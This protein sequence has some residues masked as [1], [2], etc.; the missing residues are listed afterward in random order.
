MGSVALEQPR[1]ARHRPQK[2]RLRRR[3]PHCRAPGSL[4]VRAFQLPQ[5]R[6]SPLR[7]GSERSRRWHHRGDEGKAATTGA[8]GLLLP[9]CLTW[10]GRANVAEHVG[11]AASPWLERHRAWMVSSHGI[12]SH[13]MLQSMLPLAPESLVEATQ[14]LWT[15]GKALRLLR[16]LAKV[17][18]EEGIE[19]RRACVTG[20][21]QSPRWLCLC[22]VPPPSARA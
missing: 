3:R 1:R 15:A 12:L 21:P 13:G 20:S 22:A 19:C 6:G 14:A 8:S 11:H 10:G 2:E 16:F 9:V 4:A 5:P 18:E 17:G 7:L